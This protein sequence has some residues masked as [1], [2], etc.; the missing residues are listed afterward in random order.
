M[1]CV[2]CVQ[3]NTAHCM[4][5]PPHAVRHIVIAPQECLAKMRVIEE[6]A[7][8][9]VQNAGQTEVE[10]DVKSIA[11]LLAKTKKHIVVASTMFAAMTR[12]SED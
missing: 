1:Q 11:P 4:I 5:L 8:T 6:E 7:T 10:D 2:W 3:R 9:C 12:M